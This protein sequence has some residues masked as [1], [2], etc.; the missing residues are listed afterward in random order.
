MSAK[1]TISRHSMN[2]TRLPNLTSFSEQWTC[3]RKIF[4]SIDCDS[5]LNLN[6][7]IFFSFFLPSPWLGSYN[8][9]KMLCVAFLT[10]SRLLL[11]SFW[12]FFLLL[13]V[14]HIFRIVN[15]LCVSSTRS[16]SRWRVFLNIILSDVSK[17][18]EIYLFIL[19]W[20]FRGR[21]HIDISWRVVRRRRRYEKLFSPS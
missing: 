10:T 7:L 2:L 21:T 3:E 14:K 6:L 13:F 15:I 9:F 4:H 5:T 11:F 12:F 17:E 19:V 8:V 16:Q 18:I 1:K 20:S